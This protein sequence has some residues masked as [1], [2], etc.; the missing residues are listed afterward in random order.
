MAR[1]TRSRVRMLA[2][3]A[4]EI[5]GAILAVAVVG[6]IAGLPSLL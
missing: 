6:V 2:V 5:L 1:P 3:S 4:L